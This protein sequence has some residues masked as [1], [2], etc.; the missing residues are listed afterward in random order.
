MAL[1]KK[2]VTESF[3]PDERVV[4][5]VQVRLVDGKLACAAAFDIVR[6]LDATPLDVGRTADAL[7]VKLD[8]CQLGLFGYPGKQGWDQSDIA[9]QP[10]PEGLPAALKA[11]TDA[12]GKIA[13]KMAWNLAAQFKTS[14]MLVGYLADQLGIQ[15]APCQLGAF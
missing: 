4:T 12:R 7:C 6:E 11:A 8:R 2:N 13:C 3:T 10:V 1:E 14:K 15:I 9:E 5:A